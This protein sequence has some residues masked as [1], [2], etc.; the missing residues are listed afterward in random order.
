M[1]PTPQYALAVART[2]EP[3]TETWVKHENHKPTGAFKVRGGLNFVTGC[4]VRAR[5]P[6]GL[7][8]P[9]Q[10]RPEPGVRRPARADCRSPSSCPRATP[11]TRTRR[12]RP[13]GPTSSCTAPTS[14]RPGST[15]GLAEERGLIAV[16]PLTRGWSRVSRRRPRSC[17]SGA[18]PRRVYVPVG[19]GS[20]LREHRRPRPA[21]AATEIVGVVAETGAGLLPSRSTP[22]R[23]RVHRDRRHVVDGVACRTPD[24]LAVAIDPAR[25]PPASSRSPRTRPAEAMRAQTTRTTH[26]LP[27]PAGVR[28]ALAG[29]LGERDRVAAGGSRW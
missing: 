3:G 8:D 7:R 26:N 27:E 17:T 13:S 5:R 21:R 6:A 15:P 25:P 28:L 1:P 4:G 16:P 9:R 11:P 20:D 10:P 23:G 18:R 24:P 14:R 22:G 29:L 19:M 2:G 12:R